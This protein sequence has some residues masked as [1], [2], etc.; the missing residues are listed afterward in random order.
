MGIRIRW[1]LGSNISGPHKLAR[2]TGTRGNTQGDRKDASPA[3]KATRSG[4]GSV[5]SRLMLIELAQNIK[6][7]V[8]LHFRLYCAIF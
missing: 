5:I 4:I 6:L 8:G 3:P 7:A 1:T 2:Y